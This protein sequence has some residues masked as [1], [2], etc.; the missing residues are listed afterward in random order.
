MRPTASQASGH[1][2]KNPQQMTQHV[3]DT[4]SA[5]CGHIAE[6]HLFLLSFST[7]SHHHCFAMLQASHCSLRHS[8]PVT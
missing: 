6:V 7:A 3:M 2:D 8:L 5:L 1:P 4:W